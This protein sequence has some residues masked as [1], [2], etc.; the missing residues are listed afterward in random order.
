MFGR[1]RTKANNV[2]WYRPLYIG[3]FGSR[4]DDRIFVNRDRGRMRIRNLVIALT[5][6]AAFGSDSWGQSKRLSP[7]SPPE[8]T[9]PAAPDLRGTEQSPL[10][11]RVIPTPQTDA[12]REGE[13]KE[14]ERAAKADQRKEKSDVDLVRYTAELASFTKWL[15]AATVILFLATLGLMGAAILQS[16]DMKASVEVNR[17]AAV[18]A[19]RQA[20]AMVAMEFPIPGIVDLKLVE[21]A[22]E[23]SDVALTD[24]VRSGVPPPFCRPM[25]NLQN[26]GRTELTVHRF[27]CDWIVAPAVE[28]VPYYQHVESW[29]GALAK[30][31]SVWVKSQNGI[32]LYQEEVRTIDDFAAFLWVYGYFTYSDFMGDGFAIGYIARWDTSR[33]FVRE[34]LAQYEYTRRLGR[35]TQA[36]VMRLSE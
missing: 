14:R 5:F 30:E 8:Q 11:V 16:R 13:A 23:Q 1:D 2:G 7:K 36:Q 32:R 34:P 10:V 25:V 9:Q 15:I 19:L 29:N 31:S 27:C 4:Y 20:N 22:D 18:A 12:E 21:Y 24:P 28:E 26:R 35:R 33:G 3:N 6:L 17:T